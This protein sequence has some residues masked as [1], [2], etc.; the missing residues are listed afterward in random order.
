MDFMFRSLASKIPK[1]TVLGTYS[2]EVMF[3]A[4]YEKVL[5]FLLLTGVTRLFPQPL[6]LQHLCLKFQKSLVEF[7]ESEVYAFLFAST[8][9]WVHCDDNG[10][11]LRQLIGDALNFGN[12]LRSG[13]L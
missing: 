12:D 8:E 4:N 10:T 3:E 11:P 9:G 13:N 6:N 5:L 7:H 1:G 2:C